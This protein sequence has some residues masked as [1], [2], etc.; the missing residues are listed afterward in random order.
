MVGRGGRREWEGE[1]EKRDG[2]GERER[3]W[4]GGETLH[5]ESGESLCRLVVNQNPIV[6]NVITQL[7]CVQITE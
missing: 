3:G 6:T 4:R 2:E 7:E 1:R 5:H